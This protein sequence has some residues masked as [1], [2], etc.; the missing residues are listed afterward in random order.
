[1]ELDYT[2]NDKKGK[3]GDSQNLR[4]IQ[5]RNKNSGR[6]CEVKVSATNLVHHK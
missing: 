1:M 3:K 6:M 4:G 5:S 2:K